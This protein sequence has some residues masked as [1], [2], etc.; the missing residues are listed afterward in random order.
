MFSNDY[1]EE[2]EGLS[3]GEDAANEVVFVLNNNTFSSLSIGLN[4]KAAAAKTLSRKSLALLRTCLG[5]KMLAN[6]IDSCKKVNTH[7]SL[8]MLY[9][10]FICF[11]VS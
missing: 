2:I 11:F 8:Y 7:F 5:Q 9:Y 4:A 1:G 10:M 3:M 6:M